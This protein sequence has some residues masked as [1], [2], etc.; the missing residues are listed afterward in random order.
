MNG[1][2]FSYGKGNANHHLCCDSSHRRSCLL[3]VFGACPDGLVPGIAPLAYEV[4]KKL[5]TDLILCCCAPP[6]ATP[7]SDDPMLLPAL[8]CPQH[9]EVAVHSGTFFPHWRG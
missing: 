3:D 1:V 6:G 8:K 9:G 7:Q 2:Q 4:F 5:G